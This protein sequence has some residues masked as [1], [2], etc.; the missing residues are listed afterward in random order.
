MWARDETE[1]DAQIAVAQSMAGLTLAAVRYFDLDYRRE[2][3]APDH[4][5]PRSIANEAG[6]MQPEWTFPGGH[7]VDFGIELVGVDGST[8]SLGWISP[9]VIEGLALS[10]GPM[11]NTILNP[12]APVAVWDVST[13]TAWSPLVGETVQAVRV[14]YEPWDVSAGSWWCRRMDIDFPGA[15]IEVVMAQG[16]PDGTVSPSADNLVVRFERS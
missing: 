7:T 8:W 3:F 13:R 15:S 10:R 5:G 9:G 1:R 16:N 14:R 4:D 6:W 2:E 12:E 11:L